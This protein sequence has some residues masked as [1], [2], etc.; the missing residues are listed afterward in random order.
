MKVSKWTWFNRMALFAAVPLF[1][2][3]VNR[4]DWTMVA[5]SVFVIVGNPF[6]HWLRP[7]REAMKGLSEAG[8]TKGGM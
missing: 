6:F 4:G 2:V 3:S 1:H 8:R 7:E 5:F